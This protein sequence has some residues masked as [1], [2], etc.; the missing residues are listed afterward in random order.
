MG[1]LLISWDKIC[2]PKSNGG[3]GLRKIHATNRAFQC[4][5]AWHIFTDNQSFWVQSMKAKYLHRS[6]FMDYK[7]KPTDSL[8]WKGV[9]RSREPL[10]S[11]LVWKIGDGRNTSF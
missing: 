9:V 2:Q 6:N 8:V 1:F 7:V 3:L 10:A 4:K 5:L 11:G